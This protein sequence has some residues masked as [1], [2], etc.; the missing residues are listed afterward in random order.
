MI[1]ELPNAGAGLI[2]K[3]ELTLAFLIFPLFLVMAPQND[4]CDRE[5]HFEDSQRVPVYGT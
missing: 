3:C 4:A 2:K 5:P 1:F